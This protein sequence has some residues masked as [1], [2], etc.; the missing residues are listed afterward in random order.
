MDAHAKA[1]HVQVAVLDMIAYFAVFN[2]PVSQERLVAYLPI[3]ANHLAVQE[4]I[5][6]L[7]NRRV[8]QRIGNE[9]GL[10][11]VRYIRTDSR[12]LQR[13]AQLQRARRLG[14][15][16]GLLPFVQALV[17]INSVAMGNVRASSDIDLLVVTTP[18]RIFIAKATLQRCL[19]R[20]Q[21][22][23]T[24][25]VS[26]NRF[27]LGM[28][29]T[30]RGVPIERDIMRQNEPHLIYW[31]LTAVPVYGAKSWAEILQGSAYVRGLAPNMIWPKGAK[32]IDKTGWRWLD[33]W[34]DRGY[35][36]HLKAS[37]LMKENQ[38]ADAFVRIR[39]DIINL[40][41]RDASQSIA[42]RHQGFLKLVEKALVKSKGPRS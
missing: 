29:M 40:H 20:A 28:F 3:K 42:E 16:L 34:D 22:L 12:A 4:V 2:L 21:L 14:R 17:V 5:R 24:E 26:A 13:Q 39:P 6:E 18:G 35:R 7:V 37:S 15:L 27:S 31:L 32:T 1:T 10:V 23:Q 36:R 8:L 11:G 19:N 41:P 9:Y 25:T 30:T 38:Q 33:R